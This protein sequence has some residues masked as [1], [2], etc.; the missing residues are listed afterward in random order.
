[1]TR[2]GRNN[3]NFRSKALYDARAP[4]LEVHCGSENSDLHYGVMVDDDK[5]HHGYAPYDLDAYR[6]LSSCIPSSDPALRYG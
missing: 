1:M 2:R 6:W 3:V 5:V 4:T